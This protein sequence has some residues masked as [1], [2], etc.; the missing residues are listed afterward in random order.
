MA[1]KSTRIIAKKSDFLL[2]FISIF[3]LLIAFLSRVSAQSTVSY[4]FNTCTNNNW[5]TSYANVGDGDIATNGTDATNGNYLTLTGNNCTGANLGAITKVEI[6]VNYKNNYTSASTK[7]N[8]PQLVPYFNGSGVG[9]SHNETTG[10]W[11]TQHWSVYWNIT[12]DPNAPGSWTWNDIQNLDLRCIDYRPATGTIS[13]YQ[14]EMQVTYTPVAMTF[15]SCTTTQANVTSVVPSATNQEIIGI[16]V[17]TSGI[18]SPLTT[19]SFTFNTNGSTSAANIANAKLWT[20][21]TSSTFAT[22]TQMGGA[23]VSPSGSFTISGGANMPYTLASGT[24]YFWL[25]YDIVASPSIG[26]VVDAECNS[27][28]ITSARTPSAQ[29]PSGSRTIAL[30][31]CASAG[32][33]TYQTGITFIGFNTISN[34]TPTKTLGYNDFTSQTTSV[35]KNSS[36]SLNVR[37]NSGGAYTLYCKAWFD[38]NLDGD[39]ADAGEEYTLGSVYNV[40]DAALSLSPLSITIPATASTG[41]VR[42]RVSLKYSASV[43]YPT[44]CET[45]QDGEVEDYT[46]II[47]APVAP[48]ITSLGSSNGCAGSSLI[49]TGTNFTGTSSVKIG[50]TDVTSYTVNSATQITAIVGSGTTGTVVVTTPG[51]TAT[52]ASTFTINSTPAT[53]GAITSNSPQCAGTG[54]TFTQGTCSSG[55]CYWV[56]SATGTETTNSS[57]TFTTATTAGTYNVWIRS[58]NGSCWSS[59]VTSS[60]TVNPYI[61]PVGGTSTATLTTVCSGVSTTI[62]VT[63]YTGNI[64]WEQSANGSTGWASVSGGSGATTA[65]YTTPAL[66]VTTFYRAALTSCASTVYSTTASV[67]VDPNCIIMNNNP[68]TTCSGTFYDSGGNSGNYSN[69]EN[70]TKTFTPST[71]GA[72]MRATFTAFSTEASYDKLYI[73]NGPTTASPQVSG[74]PFSGNTSPGTITSTAAN[75]ELTLTFTSDNSNN[76][77]GWAATISCYTPL[78]MTYTSSTATQTVTSPVAPFTVGQQIIGVQIVTTGAL[79][80]IDATSFTFNTNG[81]TS[82]ANDVIAATLYYTGT[83]N[84]FSTALSFGNVVSQPNGTITFTDA[85]TL[86]EGTNY[87]WL[88]YDVPLAATIGNMLDAEC[89]SI[90]VNGVVQTPSVANPGTGRPIANTYL[91]DNNSVTSCSGV[92]YDD[93]GL[94]AN[95]GNSLNYIKTFIPDAGKVMQVTFSSFATDPTSGYWDGLVIYDGPSTSSPIISSGRPTGGSSTNCPVG[96]YYDVNPGTVTATSATG[97]LT[98]QFRSDGMGT[99]AGWEATIS[100]VNLPPYCATYSSPANGA[101]NQPTNTPI[102]WTAPSTDVNHNPATSYKLYF[103]TDAAASNL[104]NGVDIGNVTNW[105]MMLNTS[106]TY[107]WKIVP[108]NKCGDAI[109]CNTIYSFTTAAVQTIT[110]LNVPGSYASIKAAYSACTAATPYIINVRT[111]YAGE[112]YPITINAD[113]ASVVSNRSAA[114]PIIIRPDAAF[115]YT[116]LGAANSVFEFSGAA[117]YVTIDGRQGGTGTANSF[118]FQNTSASKPVVSFT[119]DNS[120]NAIKYCKIQGRNQTSGIVDLKSP[121]GAGIRNIIIDNNEICPNGAFFP[122]D[123][124]YSEG[125]NPLKNTNIVISNNKVYDIWADVAFPSHGIFFGYNTF[126]FA[127]TVS[128]NSVYFTSS[129]TFTNDGNWYGIVVKGNNHIV[130]NNFVGGTAAACGGTPLTITATGT[131]GSHIYGISVTGTSATSTTTVSGNTVRNIILST[132]HRS[133]DLLVNRIASSSNQSLAGIVIEEGAATVS[134]NNI[135]GTTAGSITVI[136]SNTTD[137]ISSPSNADPNI[138]GL[139]TELAG[140]VYNSK[141]GIISNSGNTIQGLWCYPSS[142]ATT[143]LNCM[144]IGILAC[145]D[146]VTNSGYTHRITNDIIGGIGGLKAG[147]GTTSD[148]FVYGIRTATGKGS[149]YIT[150]NTISNLWVNSTGDFGNI[151]GIWNDGGARCEIENNTVTNLVCSAQNVIPAGGEARHRAIVGIMCDNDGGFLDHFFVNK[152]TV[153]DLRSTATTAKI[154]IIGIYYRHAA[155]PVYGRVFGNKVYSINAATSDMSSILT[156]IWAYGQN[157]ITYNNMIVLGSNVSSADGASCP[158]GSPVST[159]GYELRGI[160]NYF[161][162]NEYYYNSVDII[163]T[164]SGSSNTYAYKYTK[165]EDLNMYFR[166]IKDNIFSNTRTGGTGKHYAFSINI[167]EQ[168]F[169]SDYNYFYVTGTNGM[170]FD[171]NGTDKSTIALWTAASGQDAHSSGTSVTVTPDPLF[172]APNGCTGDLNI[173][174]PLSPIHNGGTTT[175]IPSYILDDIFGTSRAGTHDIGAVVIG[176]TNLPVELFSFTAEKYNEK[177]AIIKWITVSETNNDYYTLER[178]NDGIS[179]ETIEIIKGAGTTNSLKSYITYDLNPLRGLN[180]YKLKQTDYDGKYSYSQIVSLNFSDD[181]FIANIYPNPF[182]DYLYVDLQGDTNDDSL[183]SLYDMTGNLIIEKNISESGSHITINLG[184]EIPEG[185]YIIKIHNSSTMKYYKVIKHKE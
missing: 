122:T 150:G 53:P 31:Y 56:S 117:K 83:T 58:Y 155:A 184:E 66:T 145:T 27:I 21:G 171:Y 105:G 166:V 85:I 18:S 73:Y 175:N 132:K 154:N 147:N 77:A 111:G 23:T 182:N 109:G 88:A 50:G 90:T 112:T 137:D 62:T 146:N 148:G 121:T 68:V 39:F 97:E 157:T 51:G 180:Y 162:K 139:S 25:T 99:A 52:S 95:Y 38:W 63:G 168:G 40:T 102:V 161:G 136:N 178:S 84:S 45:G 131:L 10:D 9:N 104:Y 71:G 106:T 128:G 120:Y 81:T 141:L 114:N 179:F 86:S 127:C 107:Y 70:F 138:Y 174:D 78:T 170:L 87:F 103:G 153:Y 124:I 30:N 2:V 98:F 158:A 65:T 33:T 37:G 101:A 36:Y 115:S 135:G 113:V 74:S 5:T 144:V 108:T 129:K 41:N 59:S 156:G 44:C 151:R 183:L 163:G 80:P 12:S 29:A 1:S 92:Y 126:N 130:S 79:S 82:A 43:T 123:G 140:I 173:T 20:T 14:I 134:D 75:G 69:N 181:G 133:T 13:V 11:S 19:S 159:S 152:N 61:S 46:V 67:T 167:H 32:T 6:R 100:C 143:N 91:N 15:S 47:N 22:T 116:F 60:G 177:Q 94:S 160:D 172:V 26:D 42:M 76:Y 16:Q 17:V 24:N 165:E 54:I 93:G 119:G 149:I 118:V 110:T 142:S 176:N 64:Q 125:T 89:T 4:V 57:A 35:I 169:V 28:T 185:F 164:A 8:V 55:T 49:I 3:F 7:T 34:A 48:T 72:K 96:S